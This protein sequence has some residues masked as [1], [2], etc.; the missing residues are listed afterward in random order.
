MEEELG[1]QWK[2]DE[3]KKGEGNA[4]YWIGD[5][6]KETTASALRVRVNE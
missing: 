2:T 6:H 1:E 4:S 3:R 5:R